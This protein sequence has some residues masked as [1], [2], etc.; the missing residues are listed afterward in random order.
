MIILNFSHPLN[1][2]H[3][4]VIESLTGRLISR[5]IAVPTHFNLTMPLTGQ[6][7]ALLD[8]IDLAP[9]E[10]QTASL[11]I[12]LPALNVI[13]GALMAELHGRLGYFPAIIRLRPV[14]H[15][16]T[17]GYE[18]AEVINLQTMRDQARRQRVVG[19]QGQ[20]N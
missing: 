13:A 1:Q 9:V 20:S 14:T 17:V 12:N 6:V 8:Q 11:L 3:C 15:A 16:M 10:W 5:I 2:S 4:R 19:R 18:V 7:V